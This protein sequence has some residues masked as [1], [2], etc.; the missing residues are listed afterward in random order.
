MRYTECTSSCLRIVTFLSLYSSKPISSL[1][2]SL[3][4]CRDATQSFTDGVDTITPNR[5]ACDCGVV[6]MN[7]G[8][9]WS[10]RVY[11][12]PP[13]HRS[14]FARLFGASSF[15]PIIPHRSRCARECFRRRSWMGNES[16]HLSFSSADRSIFRRA[17]CRRLC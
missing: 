5:L 14:G 17:A 1:N 9:R 13:R 8:G 16:I 3:A 7:S 12:S 10:T 11:I 15:T 6:L 2:M 4:Q